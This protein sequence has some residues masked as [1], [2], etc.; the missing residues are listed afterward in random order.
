MPLSSKV[1][2]G[3]NDF[4]CWDFW[5]VW[6]LGAIRGIGLGHGVSESLLQA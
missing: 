5:G 6:G 2:G 1:H 4:L 3:L